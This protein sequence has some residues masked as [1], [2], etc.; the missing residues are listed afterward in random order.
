MSHLTRCFC[1]AAWRA[2][3]FLRCASLGKPPLDERELLAFLVLP[4]QVVDVEVGE[5]SSRAG[6]RRCPSVRHE[7]C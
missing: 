3:F 6:C 1:M 5:A 7:R 4:M 2:A